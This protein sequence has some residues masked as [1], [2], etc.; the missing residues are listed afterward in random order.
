MDIK[1]FHDR[2]MQLWQKLDEAYK[3]VES[4]KELVE[5]FAD[6]L[7]SKHRDV[8]V[9]LYSLVEEAHA[10]IPFSCPCGSLEF[11]KK[12]VVVLKNAGRYFHECFNPQRE[13]LKSSFK[14]VCLGCGREILSRQ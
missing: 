13:Q 6:A 8:R 14:Y 9:T 12:E 7:L 1:E 2:R 3:I 4:C 10:L 11:E 5:D